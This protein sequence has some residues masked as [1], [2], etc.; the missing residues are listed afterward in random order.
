MRF[1]VRV[2]VDRTVIETQLESWQSRIS[3]RSV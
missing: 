2:L 3:E 1:D